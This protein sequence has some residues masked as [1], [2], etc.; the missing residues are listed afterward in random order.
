MKDSIVADVKAL[1]S[2][3]RHPSSSVEYILALGVSTGLNGNLNGQGLVLA[4]AFGS[5]SP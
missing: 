5:R 2:L 4:W 3:I 1:G